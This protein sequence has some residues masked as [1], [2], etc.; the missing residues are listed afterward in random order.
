MKK[1][2][3]WA[4]SII[5]IV[6][7]GSVFTGLFY[8]LGT[9]PSPL[10]NSGSN[11]ISQVNISSSSEKRTIT[12]DPKSANIDAVAYETVLVNKFDSTVSTHVIAIGKSEDIARF[13]LQYS[14]FVKEL[15]SGVN[16]VVV[17]IY[18]SKDDY[19]SKKSAWK[20]AKN[21][22]TEH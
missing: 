18:K 3:K 21:T 12:P 20:F 16:E 13:A 15:N 6:I 1:Q 4:W 22:L 17:N 8:K 9:N 7:V 14:S 2:T 11:A 5:G 19:E 10:E